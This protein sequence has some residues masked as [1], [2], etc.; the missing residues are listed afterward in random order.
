MNERA[1]LLLPFVKQLGASI[2]GN[3]LSLVVIVVGVREGGASQGQ[4]AHEGGLPA[5]HIGCMSD[6]LSS[7]IP[8]S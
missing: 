8:K 4:K 2:F 1:Y 7:I 5:R 3:S 6:V